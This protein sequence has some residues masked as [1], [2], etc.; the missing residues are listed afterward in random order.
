MKFNRRSRFTLIE[1]LVVIAIIG[2]LAA[3]ILPDVAKV[4]HQDK[5]LEA[6]EKAR[7][8]HIAVES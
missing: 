3:I 8:I 6:K 1:L 5:V 4:R 7:K 2:I